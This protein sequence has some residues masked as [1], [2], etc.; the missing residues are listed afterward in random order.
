[1]SQGEKSYREVLS[2]KESGSSTD[3]GGNTAHEGGGKESRGGAR[4][5][6]TCIRGMQAKPGGKKVGKPRRGGCQL[7][8]RETENSPTVSK[9][10][11]L[12]TRRGAL[13]KNDQAKEGE[14][15]KRKLKGPIPKQMVNK[16]G[17]Q[18]VVDFLS[19]TGNVGNAR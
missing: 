9:F 1:M 2:V 19:G 14:A 6:C 4:G 15:E 11:G 7:S 18:V 13:K 17:F 10:K 8:I 5:W 12:S 3:W 16:V